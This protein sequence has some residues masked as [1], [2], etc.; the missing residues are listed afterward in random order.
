MTK[1]AKLLVA[2]LVIISALFALRLCDP[3][4]GHFEHQLETQPK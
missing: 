3:H 4:G 2:M 1:D